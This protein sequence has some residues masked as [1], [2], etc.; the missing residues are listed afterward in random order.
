MVRRGDNPVIPL[1][2]AL[3]FLYLGGGGGAV[4]TDAM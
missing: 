1:T 2:L 4:V 3:A